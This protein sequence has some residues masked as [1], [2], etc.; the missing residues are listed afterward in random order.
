MAET[1]VLHNH[2]ICFPHFPASC[3]EAKPCNWLWCRKKWHV[4]FSSQRI[5]G[6]VLGDIS[7][8]PA[9]N[10]SVASHITYTICPKVSGM[11]CE[12]LVC[13]SLPS[14]KALNTHSAQLL[15]IL[16]QTCSLTFE[17]WGAVACMCQSP[18]LSLVCLANSYPL[19]RTHLQYIFLWKPFPTLWGRGDPTLDGAPQHSVLSKRTHH[20]DN[21]PFFLSCSLHSVSLCLLVIFLLTT[22][23]QVTQN[24]SWWMPRKQ[25]TKKKVN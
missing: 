7:L 4:P 17:P 12:G 2:S 5:K 6:H 24:S 3:C 16:R 11:I 13:P 23:A 18:I 14:A 21:S 1:V 8:W 25:Q 22:N 9:Q 10:S 20:T 19:F 15:H